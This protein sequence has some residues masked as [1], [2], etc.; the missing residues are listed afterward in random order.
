MWNS[1]FKTLITVG[2]KKFQKHHGL[3]NITISRL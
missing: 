1:L 2:L 3:E